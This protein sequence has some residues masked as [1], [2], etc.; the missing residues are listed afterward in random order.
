V[1]AYPDPPLADDVVLLRPWAE[2]DLPLL[3]R[4]SGDEYVATIEHLPVPFASD[5]GRSW[6]DAQHELLAGR[7]GWSLAIVE[8]ETGEAIGGVGIVFRHPPGAA[9]PGIWVIGDRRNHG[10]AERA[11]RLLCSWVLTTGTG[12]ERIQATV[13]PWNVAS[14]RVLEKAG[15]VRE[16]LLRSYASWRGSRQDVLLYS[17]L[18]GDLPPGAA[19]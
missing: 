16:G 8:R 10:V 2:S 19:P 9:E 18:A 4:A 6:I 7:R 11:T 3:E 12:I 17:L 1:L 13:E 14:Q 15:F 5:D